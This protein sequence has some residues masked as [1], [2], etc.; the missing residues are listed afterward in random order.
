MKD[1]SLFF[2]QHPLVKLLLSLVLANLLLMADL[3][4]IAVLSAL[5]IL[6]LLIDAKLI[7]I[8]LKIA[9]KILPLI[10]VI[11]LFGIISNDNFLNTLIVASRLLTLL[12]ISVYIFKTSSLSQYR[13]L[14]PGNKNFQTWLQATLLFIPLF[15]ENYAIAQ[16]QSG[17]IIEIIEKSLTETHK[18]IDEVSIQAAKLQKDDNVF[19]YKADLPAFACI[20]ASI[21]L[22]YFMEL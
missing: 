3:F 14:M 5:F 10:M 6:Y 7:K 1:Q 17:N 15:F 11:L 12:L 18:N 16:K 19:S 9:I 2:K 13:K 20:I 8:W 21:V 4:E 22:F